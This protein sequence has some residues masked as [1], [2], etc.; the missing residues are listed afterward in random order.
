MNIVDQTIAW[1]ADPAHWQGPTGVPARMI[2]H[3]AISG[4]SLLIAIAI[5]LPVGLYIGHTGR[6]VGIAVNSAN[7]WRALPSLAVIGIVLPI[8]AALD[9]RAGFLVYPT[10]VAMVVLGVPPILVNTYAGISGVDHD[11]IEAARGQGLSNRQILRRVEIPLAV[12][13]VLAGIRS[14]AVQII[15][16][17]TLGA[18]FGFGGL[19]RY[20][21]DGFAQF[22]L[23]GAAQMMA[24]V[25]LVATLV[26]ATDV[27]FRVTQRALTPKGSKQKRST[28]ASAT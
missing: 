6:G 3:A 24:G 2:E 9:P 28:V 26:M 17:A 5:A 19:G 27:A 11:V 1:L 8:T 16:T 21:V 22:S 10:V 15:A 14:S 23:G 4:V 12:P 20:L 25:V 18:V 13:V 7:L